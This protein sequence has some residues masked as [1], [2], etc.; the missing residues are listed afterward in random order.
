MDKIEEYLTNRLVSNKNTRK[1]YRHHIRKYFQIINADIRTYFQPDRDYQADIIRFYNSLRGRPLKSTQTTVSAVKQFLCYHD[2]K[3]KEL[4]L[5]DTISLRLKGAEPV[6]EDFIPEPED[7]AKILQHLDVRGRAV[8]LMGTSSGMRIEELML[9]QPNDIHLDEN[10]VRINLR[11]EIVKGRKKK[12]TTFIS[13]E[14]KK[15]LNAWLQVRDTYYETSRR[16]SGNLHTKKKDDIRV[17]PYDQKTLRE[18]LYRAMSKAGYTERDP[19]TG[20][21]KLHFH[22]FR[23]YFRTYFGNADLAEH[24]MGHSGYLSTYRKY[25]ERKLA[26]EYNKYVRNIA[27][28]E[29][30]PDL[31]EINKEM[32]EKEQRIHKLE[33]KMQ[34][35]ERLLNDKEHLLTMY[36]GMI[37]NGSK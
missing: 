34:Q 7:I 10:P 32:T 16:R 5:W 8:V 14:A 36:Q 37:K 17:F 33:D 20:R 28:I 26:E 19:T 18:S 23:K 35:M 1:L 3:I 29:Q 12:R 21:M 11:A 9:L 30:S 24:L 15:A 27:V 4:D 6:S 31:Q 22:C 25:P 2:K 13:N